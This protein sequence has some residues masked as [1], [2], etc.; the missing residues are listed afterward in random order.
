LVS[1][2]PNGWTGLAAITAGCGAPIVLLANG[3]LLFA[4]AAHG[5]ALFPGVTPLMGR[6]PGSGDLE[7]AIY[8]PKEDGVHPDR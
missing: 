2:S 1:G 7:R 4:P 5:G 6:D 3:G 8:I